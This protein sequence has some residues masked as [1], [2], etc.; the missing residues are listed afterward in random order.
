MR[1][2]RLVDVTMHLLKYRENSELPETNHP[3]YKIR[4]I[5]YNCIDSA[6][7]FIKQKVLTHNT[8]MVEGMPYSAS[9]VQRTYNNFSRLHAVK[10]TNLRLVEIPDSNLIDCYV[11]YGVNKPSTIIFQP[12]GT[13]TAGDLGAAVSVTYQNRNLFHGSELLS[14]QLRGA[15]EAITGLEGY[16]NEDYMEYGVESKI[17]FPRFVAP[18]PSQPLCHHQG[19]AAD[20]NKA[21]P[22][23]PSEAGGLF[24]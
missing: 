14:V 10:S 22:R 5:S 11:Q 8:A 4:N 24:Q 12:E 20:G 13:N 15:F 19:A 23:R 2:S 17:S 6:T 3:C 16:Q 1:G 7:V 21:H 9:D 18:F